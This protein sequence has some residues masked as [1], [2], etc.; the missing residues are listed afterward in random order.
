MK[1][2]AGVG[3]KI[4]WFSGLLFYPFETR[5]SSVCLKLQSVPERKHCF[6]VMKVSWLMP[7]IE[8]IAF[9]L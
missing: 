6:S 2:Q 4:A 9:L 3:I 8:M 5:S 7:F 1:V